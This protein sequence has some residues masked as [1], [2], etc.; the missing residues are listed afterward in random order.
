MALITL[1]YT[2]R[3]KTDNPAKAGKLLGEKLHGPWAPNIALDGCWLAGTETE[4]VNPAPYGPNVKCAC[5]DLIHTDQPF[6]EVEADG[7]LF[8]WNEEGG[9]HRYDVDPT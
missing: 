6:V 8:H 3:I 1:L 5:G 2:V 7:G 4:D 9:G